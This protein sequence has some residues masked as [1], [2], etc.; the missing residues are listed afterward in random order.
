MKALLGL[1][2]LTALFSPS[3]EQF[4]TSYTS[5]LSN[6]PGEAVFN[7]NDFTALLGSSNYQ[8]KHVFVACILQTCPTC[9]G[10]QPMYTDAANRLAEQYPGKVAFISVDSY[11]ARDFNVQYGVK[12]VPTY[13]LFEGE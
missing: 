9:K 6:M 4:Q 13:M 10:A 8:G 2:F 1:L 3:L 7:L 5:W 11:K 12:K